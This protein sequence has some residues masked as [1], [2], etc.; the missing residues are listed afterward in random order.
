[1]VRP[2]RLERATSWFVARRSIDACWHLRTESPWK[3]LLV[4][5]NLGP[6]PDVWRLLQTSRTSLAEWTDSVR[7]QHSDWLTSLY[8]FRIPH[9]GSMSS[10]AGQCLRGPRCGDATHHALG[11][12]G[13][14]D[15][16]MDR[17]AVPHDRGRDEAHR[18][19]IHDRD[20]IYSEGV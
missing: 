2:A 1:M 6:T 7:L 3:H 18:F 10:G 19:V 15:R 14:S 17:T 12:H 8:N 20:S 11:Y 5:P 13:T 9:P 16:R 4:G